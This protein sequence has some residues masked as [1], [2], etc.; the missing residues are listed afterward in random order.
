MER[1]K[2]TIQIYINDKYAYTTQKFYTIKEAIQEARRTKHLE[3]ASIPK[4]YYI[5]I[6]DYD[7][8]TGLY[9]DK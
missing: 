2:R 5:T 6:Y 8:L 7:K 1:R 4:N 9:I 3:I